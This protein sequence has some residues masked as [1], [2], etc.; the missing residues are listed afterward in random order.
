MIFYNFIVVMLV[1]LIFF[2]F[3]I[4]RNIEKSKK[5][6][7]YL[8]GFFLILITGIRNITVGT[9]VKNY[10]SIFEVF[11]ISTLLD[12][13]PSNFNGMFGYRILCRIVF[14]L[15]NGNYQIMLLISGIILS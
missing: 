13:I 5:L 12:E 7:L 4:K 14:I 10:S 1:L 9:D 2:A 15:T 6:F 8:S 11:G 3:F